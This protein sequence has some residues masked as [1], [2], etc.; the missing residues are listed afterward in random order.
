[1]LNRIRC[2]YILNTIMKKMIKDKKCLDLIN[3]I[4]IY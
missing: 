1:M 3:N 4:K 2:K